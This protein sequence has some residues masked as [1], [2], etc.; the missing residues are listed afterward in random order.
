MAIGNLA[1]LCCIYLKECGKE[2]VKGIEVEEVEVVEERVVE[3]VVVEDGAE[4][5]C[6]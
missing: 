3:E 5:P 1:H 2:G 6:L 4:K